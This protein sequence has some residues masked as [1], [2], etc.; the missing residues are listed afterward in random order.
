ML[1]GGVYLFGNRRPMNT[2]LKPPK[3]LPKLTNEKAAQAWWGN[4]DK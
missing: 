3:I 4:W 1:G 2:L